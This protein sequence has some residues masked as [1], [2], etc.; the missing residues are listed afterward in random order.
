MYR[1][2]AR[3]A[4]GDVADAVAGGLVRDGHLV[5]HP[6]PV[7][8][9]LGVGGRHRAVADAVTAVPRLGLQVDLFLLGVAEA[10]DEGVGEVED[11]LDEGRVGPEVGVGIQRVIAPHRLAVGARHVA[12]YVVVEVAHLGAGVVL[13]GAVHGAED[14]GDGAFEPLRGVGEE[15]RMIEYAL[16]SSASMFCST[17]GRGPMRYIRLSPKYFQTSD[18]GPRGRASVCWDG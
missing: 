8:L 18:C 7:L 13:L 4:L 17:A 3:E 11:L 10:L 9:E 6:V 15:R 5:H 16:A 2:G 14:R 1:L 12:L